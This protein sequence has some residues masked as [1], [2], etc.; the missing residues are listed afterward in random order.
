MLLAERDFSAM[1]RQIRSSAI[2]EKQRVSY[3]CLSRLTDLSYIYHFN[4]FV[5]F[6]KSY[7][8]LLIHW[9][10]QVLYTTSSFLKKLCQLI[11][12]ALSVKY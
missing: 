2:A 7:L 1:H 9:T 3:A 11:F 4:C 10:L 6:I 12:C 5:A 8:I